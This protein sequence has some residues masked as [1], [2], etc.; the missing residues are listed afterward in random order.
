MEEEQVIR[1]LIADVNRGEANEIERILSREYDCDVTVAGSLTAA[2]RYVEEMDFDLVV[3]DLDLP[4]GRGLALANLLEGKKSPSPL[5]I[6]SGSRGEKTAVEVFRSGAFGYAKK[7]ADLEADLLSEVERALDY[8]STEGSPGNRNW[9]ASIAL[10]LAGR[11]KE[12]D[13]LY[14]I[15]K[16]IERQGAK[17]DEILKGTVKLIP[18]SLQHP[19]SAGARVIVDEKQYESS[20]FKKTKWLISADI[21]VHL[22]TVGRVEVCYPEKAAR[23]NEY[24]FTREEE[25]LIGAIAKRIGNAIENLRA[26]NELRIE[27]ALTDASLNKLR[28]LFFVIDLEGKFL[29]WNHSFQHFTGKSDEELES[30]NIVELFPDFN[31]KK[32]V[33]QFM[34]LESGSS[35]K[36]EL[37]IKS[38]VA[39]K[40]LFEFDGALLANMEGITDSFC[41]IG[42][43]IT[44]HKRNE[45]LLKYQLEMTMQVIER[46]DL[47][48]ILETALN[49]VLDSTGLDLGAAYLLDDITSSYVLVLDR[50]A[51]D[52]FV[53]ELDEPEFQAL[54]AQENGAAAPV[55]LDAG[56]LPGLGILKENAGEVLKSGVLAVIYAA[57]KATGCVFAASSS[58]ETI[59]ES[60]LGVI[61]TLM[62][63]CNQAVAVL[64]LEEKLRSSENKLRQIT[65]SVRD[66][67]FMLDGTGRIV[68][69]NPAAQSLFGYSPEEAMGESLSSLITLEGYQESIERGFMEFRLTESDPRKRDALGVHATGKDGKVI[70]LEIALSSIEGESGW[71]TVGIARE[72]RQQ[73]CLEEEIVKFKNIADNS[74]Y[75]VVLLDLKGKIQYVNPYL[76]S[77]HGYAPEELLMKDV[78]IF[79]PRKMLDRVT[80]EFRQLLKQGFLKSTM[81]WHIKKD[82]SVFPM[83]ISASVIKD[84]G[85]KPLYIA[86]S[87][88]DISGIKDSE[89]RLREAKEIAEAASSAKSSF[90]AAISHEIRTPLSGVIGMARVLSET[91]LTREQT[92]YATTIIE[93]SEVLLNI[94]NNILDFATLEASGV[95]IKESLFNIHDMTGATVK[96]FAVRAQEKGLDLVFRVDP[97][98]PEF[99][100]GDPDR[101]RHI[102]VNLLGNAVKFTEQGEVSVSL[103]AKSVDRQSATLIF[104]IRDTGIGIPGNKQEKIFESFTQVDGS[105]NRQ[106]GGAGLGLSVSHQLVREMKGSM[107]LVSNPGKGSTFSFEVK[108]G[109]GKPPRPDGH[110]EATQ[111]LKGVRALIALRSEAAGVTMEGALTHWGMLPTRVGDGKNALSELVEAVDSGNPFSLLVLDA[112]LPEVDGFTIAKRIH[113]NPSLAE[114]ILFTLNPMMLKDSIPRLKALGIENYIT[115]PVRPSDLLNGVMAARNIPVRPSAVKEPREKR[116]ET[117][118]SLKVLLA[119][120]TRV[121]Q[122]LMKTLLGKKGHVVTTANNGREALDEMEK[123]DFDLVLMD[124]Q[125]PVM[126]GFEATRIIRESEQENGKHVPIVALTAHSMKGDREKCLEGGMDSYLSKPVDPD[127]L[128]R[129]LESYSKNKS[130][131]G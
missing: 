43:D 81:R 87:G 8:V 73:K 65:D 29:R 106:Y 102:I 103:E 62:A 80:R 39:E 14:G 44:G 25:K 56:E 108:F 22:E 89:S 124:V 91:E 116:K 38:G 118:V 33:K 75:G 58:E 6:V 32:T 130:K 42:R 48:V 11:T 60:E 96:A 99:V 40:L 105:W 49:A 90:L 16:L 63:Q 20:G 94:I 4:E 61:N 18:P 100:I 74:E 17:L 64:K 68:F 119:E 41:F 120:D 15:S 122:K 113:E 115:T 79:F 24:P 54:A 123:E 69:W 82:N 127:D 70:P 51:R 126:D 129:L 93:S 97:D 9:D 5:I 72:N 112:D 104:F 37:E 76:A 3:S 67:I 107:S 121:N 50:G 2:K 21:E 85:G 117:A 28:D 57:G 19:A 125:M 128:Y 114:S 83:L 53:N 95:E 13:C 35:N 55:C 46:G 45:L 92:E 52:Q 59:P 26:E 30:M 88:I 101:L 31:V 98:V 27:K 10:K 36:V 34:K 1:V 7:G 78:G 111:D 86:A 84:D 131:E 23:Q 77:V 12:L 66:P 47:K 71:Q 110:V 109:I